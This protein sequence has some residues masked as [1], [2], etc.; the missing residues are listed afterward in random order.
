MADAPTSPPHV[1]LNGWKEIAAYVGKSVRSVQRWQA[2]LGLPVHRI[3]TPHG[4]IVYAAAEE[5]DAWRRE[6]DLDGHAAIDPT[7]ARPVA[8]ASAPAEAAAPAPAAG[9]DARRFRLGRHYLWL[10]PAIVLLVA[11]GT[12][13]FRQPRDARPVAVDFRFGSRTLEALG[14]DGSVLWTHRFDRDVSAIGEGRSP[15]NFHL[16]DVDDDQEPEVLVLVRFAQRGRAPT[17]SDGLFCFRRDG[18]LMWSVIPDQTL[19]FGGQRYGAP[20]KIQDFVA[21]DTAGPR[22][23]WLA[24]A[25]HTWWPGFVLEI[26]SDGAPSVRYAQAGPVSSLAHWVTPSGGVLAVGGVVSSRLE[27]TVALLKDGDPPAT[28]PSL[29]SGPYAC[30]G[31]PQAEPHRVF[32]FAVPGH[33][34]QFLERDPAVIGVAVSGVG[35]TVRL[36]DGVRPAGVHGVALFGPNLSPHSVAYADRYW[37]FHRELELEGVVDHTVDEC[38]ERSDPRVVREWTPSGWLDVPTETDGPAD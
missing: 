14:T 2:T 23:F 19:S 34:R 9:G 30:V 25:H 11:S 16:L 5:I 4:Q 27:A 36:D 6:R 26:G 18:A 24:L 1:M 33:A 38:P 32:A 10:V 15:L 13:W 8:R 7:P 35:L 29:G 3:R 22:R 37:R 21:S 20:W 12:V 31:C 28:F 17:M